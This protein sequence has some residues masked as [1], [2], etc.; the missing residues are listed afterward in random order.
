MVANLDFIQQKY[1][2][3]L[4]WTESQASGTSFS[5]SHR[6]ELI[7]RLKRGIEGALKR[8]RI[9][10]PSMFVWENQS[11]QVVADF[12]TNKGLRRRGGA[13]RYLATDIKFGAEWN[14]S[15]TDALFDVALVKGIPGGEDRTEITALKF[16]T[17][18]T[19][20]EFLDLFLDPVTNKYT[21]TIYLEAYW[22]EDSTLPVMQNVFAWNAFFGALSGG[23][24][25]L[26]MVDPEAFDSTGTPAGWLENM[27]VALWSR[28]Y[29]APPVYGSLVELCGLFWMHGRSKGA[30]RYKA[31]HNIPWENLGR[32]VADSGAG[33]AIRATV[34][35]ERFEGEGLPEYRELDYVAKSHSETNNRDWMR[36]APGSD[37]VSH[38][39]FG[40]I[41]GLEPGTSA[42][43]KAVGI[44]PA[45]VDCIQVPWAEPALYALQV[46]SESRCN[47]PQRIREHATVCQNYNVGRSNI[48]NIRDWCFTDAGH[49]DDRTQ[50]EARMRWRLKGT[51][52]VGQK[53][54]WCIRGLRKAG[55]KGQPLDGY[56]VE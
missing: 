17:L 33:W 34:P 37:P 4:T 50:N 19:C 9:F 3:E 7:A 51:P 6:P 29:G 39:R 1:G 21:H 11:K 13:G 2:Y 43:L 20:V 5:V 8:Q 52:F 28:V 18:E 48:L 23:T 47:T 25:K 42:D 56:I 45:G 27:L 40:A 46:V 36:Q 12:R 30:N 10:G 16:P 38:I 31:A 24:R 53:S 54:E 26:T 35:G 15:L 55:G 32:N 44:H 14:T 41:K 49:R 22:L